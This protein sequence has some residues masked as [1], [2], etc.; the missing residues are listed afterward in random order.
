MFLLF[1]V[2]WLKEKE[3]RVFEIPFEFFREL[4]YN[5]KTEQIRGYNKITNK[6]DNIEIQTIKQKKMKQSVRFDT[7]EFVLK[8]QIIISVIW[9]K[10]AR[11]FYG[12]WDEWKKR[13]KERKKLDQIVE[14][15]R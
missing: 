8:V 3:K 6:R 9:H 1:A 5:E 2:N 7:K 4:P 15:R 14:M 13:K 10:N 12:G 11:L